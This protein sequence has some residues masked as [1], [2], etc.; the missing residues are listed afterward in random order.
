MTEDQIER[1]IE[2]MT[3][4]LDRM[5]MDGMF[6]QRYYDKAMRDL[7]EWAEAQYSNRREQ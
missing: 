6:S 5:F 4:H 3:D 2:M 1:R 7:D